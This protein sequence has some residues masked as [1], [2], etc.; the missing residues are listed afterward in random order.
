MTWVK[1]CGI[2]NIEDA[3]AAVEMGADALGFVF[4]QNSPRRVDPEHAG[5][6]VAQPPFMLARVSATIDQPMSAAAGSCSALA[7]VGRVLAFSVATP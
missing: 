4:H 6:I 7:S 1:I 5:R 3:L 2:P